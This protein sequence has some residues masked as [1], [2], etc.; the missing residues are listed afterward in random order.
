M[1]RR[2][3][4]LIV[5]L[6]V[7]VF[8]L[9]L[10]SGCD[11]RHFSK[12]G[13]SHSGSGSGEDTGDHD[14]S[15]TVDNG[16]G[17]VDVDNGSTIEGVRVVVPPGA[18]DAG[19]KVTIYI[20]HMSGLP[21]PIGSGVTQL[22]DGIS[23]TKDD[24]HKF[25]IPVTV[26]IP[27]N[28]DLLGEGEIPGA[29]YWDPTAQ[30]YVALGVKNID[31]ENHVVSFTTVQLGQFVIL[32]MGNLGTLPA[33]DSGFT[34]C[35]DG[36]FHPNFGAYDFPGSSSFAMSGYSEW[37]YALQRGA[38]D[39]HLYNMYREGNAARWEDDVTARELVSRAYADAS[40]IWGILWS[41]PDYH[42]NDPVT[43]KL[44]IL[45]MSITGSPQTLVLSGSGFGHAVTV[46]DWNKDTGL[47]SVYDSNFPCEA[48]TLA[49]DPV[50]GFSNY[51]KAAGYPMILKYSFDSYLTAYGTDELRD[52]YSGA[53]SGWDKTKF[54]IISVTQPALD[55]NDVGVVPSPKDVVVTGQVTGGL[56]KAQYLVYNVNGV[57]GFAGQLVTLDENGYFT[58]TI[59][60]LFRD[61]NSIMLITS[62]DPQDATRRVPRSYA[63]FKEFFLKVEGKTHF[64]RNMGFETGDFSYWN[65]KTWYI[66]TMQPTCYDRCTI[67]TPGTDP[68]FK[69]LQKVLIGDYSARIN[70]ISGD[71]NL[72]SIWQ[73]AVVPADAAYPEIRFYWAAV[74]EDSDWEYWGA[75]GPYVE[76]LL[77]DDTTGSVLYH[78]VFSPDDDSYSGWIDISQ[79]TKCYDS[80]SMGIP[81]QTFLYACPPEIKGHTLTLTISAADSTKSAYGGYLYLDGDD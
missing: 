28:P 55:A 57:D 54:Q 81:W 31:F 51:S 12:Y 37:Y 17:E 26:Y 41:E 11:F 8:L 5:K 80:V 38:E 43:G 50:N 71:K 60:E 76:I 61:L 44:L 53:Q 49:W 56:N 65:H 25:I 68:I 4:A 64:F 15:G 78:N 2:Q 36:F 30:K 45:A 16:G 6:V 48:V 29:F 7:L 70:D 3:L 18:V 34:P 47:F 58:F 23:I 74:L 72:S 32:S 27:Y 24:P 69:D 35:S 42:L 9:S 10:A 22:S 59:P 62:N 19:R 67:Q 1:M 79:I 52:L 39:S 14:G 73:S 63:G 75:S 40:H 66:P 21:G 20:D 33:V 77:K 46:Y 13:S